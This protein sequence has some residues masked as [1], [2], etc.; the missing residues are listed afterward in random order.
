MLGHPLTAA[1]IERFQAEWR[2]RPE[3]AE[4]LGALAAAPTTAA[5]AALA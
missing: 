1:G 4:W 5:A 2:S 3:L